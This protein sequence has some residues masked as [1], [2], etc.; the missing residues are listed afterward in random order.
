MLQLKLSKK[1]LY[2]ESTNTF[3][4][5]PEQTII[6]EHSL[7]SI[8]KWESIWKKPF[9]ETE[10]LTTQETVSYIECMCVNDGFDKNAFLYLNTLELEQIKEYMKDSM[11]ATWFRKRD[12]DSKNL[13]KTIITSELIYYWMISFNIPYEF[14]TW[15]INRLMTLIRIFIEKNENRDK[16]GKKK[17]LS[18]EAISRRAALNASRKKQHNTRG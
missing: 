11:T 12:E 6:L 13:N 16:N 7:A 1:N 4:E 3:L 15:H 2:D 8:S 9:F 14:E 10:E 17:I 18:R 5:I